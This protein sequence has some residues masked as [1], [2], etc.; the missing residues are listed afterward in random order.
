[1]KHVIS[2]RFD[3]EIST[4]EDENEKSWQMNFQF[5]NRNSMKQVHH[6]G[7]RRYISCCLNQHLVVCW[8]HILFIEILEIE[9]EVCITLRLTTG[10]INGKFISSKSSPPTTFSFGFLIPN[11]IRVL[12][13][14]SL[15]KKMLTQQQN[16][17]K[18]RKR[19]VNSI[20]K[21]AN[22]T[23]P[24]DVS[25]TRFLS[26]SKLVKCL[27]NFHIFSAYFTPF[28]LTD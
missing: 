20:V 12:N 16:C 13:I 1:M 14:H 10:R 11:L 4:I 8:L 18:R 25:S 2:F 22:L 19:R 9:H 21:N 5:W 28:C 6:L 27:Q 15:L 26:S 24:L 23:S 7:Y 17:M 3:L